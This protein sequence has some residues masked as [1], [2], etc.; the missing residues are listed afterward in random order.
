[1]GRSESSRNRVFEKVPNTQGWV[2]TRVADPSTFTGDPSLL[3]YNAMVEQ[4]NRFVVSNGAQT[5][6]ILQ[7][8]MSELQ[9]GNWKYEPDHPNFTPRISGVINTDEAHRFQL[10]MLRKSV[11]GDECDILSYTYDDIPYGFGYFI[12]TYEDDGNPLPSFRDEPR[13]LPI[14]HRNPHIIALAF[15][16]ILNE[17]NRVALAV[18]VI[19]SDGSP[20]R[21]DI[22]NRFKIVG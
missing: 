5:D 17:E 16:N 22:I 12:S 1:M 18:K 21:V 20:S 9:S 6:A 2:K 15:W 11:A 8:G 3:I 4:P 13:I 14:G 7:N 10:V 19:P